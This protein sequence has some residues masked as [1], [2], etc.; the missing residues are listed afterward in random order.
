MK[1]IMPSSARGPL[2]KSCYHASGF[3][4]VNIFCGRPLVAASGGNYFGAGLRD[5]A[6]NSDIR[7]GKRVHH[8]ALTQAGSVVLEG[9]EV[10]RFIMA[11]TAQ[12]VGVGEFRQVG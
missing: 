2:Q 4:R 3:E 8:L 12:A 7:A 1:G 11:E 6:L 5:D 9:D 10:V